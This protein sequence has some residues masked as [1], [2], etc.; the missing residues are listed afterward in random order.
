MTQADPTLGTVTWWEIPVTDLDEAA[1]FY[2]AVF[3]WTVAPFG[4]GFLLV[5]QGERMI[6]G[7]FASPEPAAEGVRIYV[8]VA[9]LEA[10]L[11]A[12]VTAGGSVVRERTLISPEM[13]WWAELADPSGRRIGLCS[14]QGPTA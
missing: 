14:G 6:G 5:H 3:G 9:D 7:L 2:P 1:R 8:N 12:A 13:G 10:V 11:A 4:D